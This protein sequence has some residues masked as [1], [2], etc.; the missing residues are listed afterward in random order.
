[1]G[2][3]NDSLSCNVSI[4]IVNYN[5][6]SLLNQCL[7]SIQEKTE[8]LSYEILVVD[9][10][11]EEN[12]EEHLKSSYPDVKFIRSS[13]N[14]GFGK[15]NNLGAQ[16]AHGKYLFFLNSDTLLINNAIS[17]LYHFIE[18]QSSIGICGANLYDASG[19]PNFSYFPF[20]SVRE[21]LRIFLPAKTHMTKYFNDT[22]EPLE[23]DCISGADLMIR[24]DIFTQAGKFDPDFFLY[25]EETELTWRVRQMGYRVFS[26]PGA[27]IIHYHGMSVSKEIKAFN[28]IY[29]YSKFLYFRK[30]HHFYTP[31][32]IKQ[33]HLVKCVIALF[34][35]SL[36][37]KKEKLSY[38]RT[39]YKVILQ[40]YA[41]Y[42]NLFRQKKKKNN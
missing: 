37:R 18:K 2:Q 7:S 30:T 9:N 35:F 11:S 38:W 21:E 16:Q 23:V 29:L 5:T 8:N 12:P 39:K 3:F 32:V 27:R 31:F 17:I 25:Y 40:L 10:A 28:K 33:I 36:Y 22:D 13:C 42:Q 6:L 15:A 14:L 1:M 24:K 41:D 26:V 20:P 19:N 4:I 34:Y